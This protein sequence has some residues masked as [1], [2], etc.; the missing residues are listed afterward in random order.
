MAGSILFT[1]SDLIKHNEVGRLFKREKVGGI[2]ARKIQ[3][4]YQAI[5]TLNTKHY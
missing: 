1:P 3:E 2:H 5:Y 4:R